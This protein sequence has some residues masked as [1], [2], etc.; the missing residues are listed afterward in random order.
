M[1]R[2][3]VIKRLWWATTAV[4]ALSAMS[5]PASSAGTTAGLAPVTKQSTVHT[6][7][8]WV[9][10]V[11]SGGARQFLGVPYAAPPVNDRRFAPPQPVASW[12][13]V[14]P[15]TVQAPACV[16]FQPKGVRNEQ[17]TS[18]DCLYLDIYTPPGV[19]PKSMLPVLFFVHGGGGT[20]GSGVLYGGERFTSLTNAIF[21]SV[22]YRLGAFGQ[23]A[24]PQLDGSGDFAF[25]DQLA[26]LKWVTQNIAEFGGDPGNV[27]VDGQS[28]GS[29]A[30]CDMLASPQAAGLFQ[31]AVLES[32]PCNLGTAT[33]AA[34]QAQGRQFAAA[35][36]CTD[37]AT[38]VSC[39]RAAW[40][41]DLVAVQQKYRPGGLAYGTPLLPLVPKDAIQQGKWNKVPVIVGSTRWEYKLQDVD[42]ADMTPEQYTAAI[43]DQ[44]GADAAAVLAH[45]PLANYPAP[46]YAYAALGTDS[47]K[48][49]PAYSLAGRLGTQVP[50]W[51][52]E[53]DDPTSPTLFGFQ[54]PG[55]DMSSAHSA[56]LAYLWN[57]ALGERP[58]TGVQLTLGRQMDRYWGAFARSGR[59]AAPGLTAWPAVTASAHPVLDFRP[60]G[61]TVSSTLFA[62]EHQCGFWSGLGTVS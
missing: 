7:D 9:Q 54:P 47:G 17:A 50:T 24:L 58:L 8:G 5:M 42:D 52:E 23:L 13:G 29:M 21:V 40:T 36:G 32:T 55:I 2:S 48:A 43:R 53:F 45:Y 34:A 49:C 16:Q 15:A 25:L 19:Q 6:Q 56:E 12:D 1:P 60:S 38:I 37:A 59:P 33:L 26:A 27:T 18:E 31:R 61:N 41:P 11:V 39:L 22:N 3:T 44:F 10:G 62:T 28:A 30:V 14:R 46:F 57:F 35:A 20:Q 4:I 51:Q